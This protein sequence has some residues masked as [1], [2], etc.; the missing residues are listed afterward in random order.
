MNLNTMSLVKTTQV[1]GKRTKNAVEETNADDGQKSEEREDGGAAPGGGHNE[2][3][4]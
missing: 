4:C 2:G 1:S 3:P